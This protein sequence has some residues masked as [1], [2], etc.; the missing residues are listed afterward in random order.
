M[1]HDHVTKQL[2]L[3]AKPKESLPGVNI[4]IL[5]LRTHI[6]TRN[7]AE[8]KRTIAA[9]LAAPGDERRG[10]PGRRAIKPGEATFPSDLP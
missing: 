9:A 1:A 6:D 4:N 3:Q 8:T 5:R 10:M 2:G 7:L